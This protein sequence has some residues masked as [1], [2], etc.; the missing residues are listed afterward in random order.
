MDEAAEGPHCERELPLAST[1][2]SPARD[3]EMRPDIAT[4][5]AGS[6]E[7]RDFQS[8]DLLTGILILRESFRL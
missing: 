5:E 3:L 4:R 8:G 1:L 7:S 6:R 2:A